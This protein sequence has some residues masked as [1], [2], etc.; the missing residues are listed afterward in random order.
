[1][2]DK[3]CTTFSM[4]WMKMTNS[5][6]E[7]RAAA[8]LDR[9]VQRGGVHKKWPQI[10]KGEGI[11]HRA[12]HP[13][14]TDSF[15]G[16]LTRAPNGQW[17]IMTNADIENPGRLNF[18]IAHELG[19]YALGH[20]LHESAFFCSED[21]IIEDGGTASAMEREANHFATCL[22]MP[23]DKLRRAFTSM[24]QNSHRTRQTD[25]LN[26]NNSTFRIWCGIRKDL[27]NRYGVSETALRYRLQS[28][29]LA[30]F[31]F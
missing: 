24:L 20:N 27:T 2:T 12:I 10:M 21:S 30:C 9:Y 8:M 17:Y 16:A 14:G 4:R 29:R 23:E 1:M 15:L 6:I 31:S 18:T 26:V 13:S 3:P 22:L 25:S 19:H 7:A 11:K 28:L 5:E